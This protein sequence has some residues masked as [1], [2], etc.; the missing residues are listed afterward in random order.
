M[1]RTIFRNTFLVGSTVLLLCAAFFFG[2]QYTQAKEATT[3]ALR[4]EIE[5][6]KEGLALSGP[7]YLDSLDNTNRVTWISADGEVLY[8]NQFPGELP[9]QLNYPE[10][11]QAVSEGTGHSIRRSD[12]SRES[13]MYYAVLCTDGSVLRLSRPLEAVREALTSVSMMVWIL[14]LLLLISIVLSFRAAKQI[15]KPINAM[16]LDDPSAN[17]YPEL[18]PLVQRIQDQSLTIR[19]EAEQR[20]ELRREFSANVSHELKTP[21]TSISGFA[22]LMQQGLV[23]PAKIPEF[24]GDIYRESQRLIALVDDIIR[25]S[26]LDENAIAPDW[27]PVDLYDLSADILDSLRPAAGQQ[28]ISLSLTGDHLSVLGIRSLLSEMVYNLC[29]NAIKYNHPGGSVTVSLSKEDKDTLLRVSDTGIGIPKNSQDRVF[30]RFYRVD[31]SHSKGLGG[32]GLGL[33]IVKHGAQFHGAD[34]SLESDLGEG[35]V[36]TLRFPEKREPVKDS[37]EA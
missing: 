28:N 22:E 11:Q 37:A 29:D 2:L 25:L 10:V 36:I 32:T 14:I 31:K 35:T 24:S 18:A 7:S 27:E 3:E 8:D 21:L 20:E 5:Y 1:V 12:S 23:P 19:E 26:K 13:T 30:E 17:P 15:V 34:I 6:A 33:S 16:D 9:N 4:Q